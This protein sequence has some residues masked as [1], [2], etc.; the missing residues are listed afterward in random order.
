MDNISYNFFLQTGR[1]LNSLESSTIL[2]TGNVH[3]YFY[4]L[5][6]KKYVPIIEFLKSSMSLNTNIIVTYKITGGIQ[7][8]NKND[9][10]LFSNAW[11]YWR[12]GKENAEEF[13]GLCRTA[14]G[15]ITYSLELLKQMC[16]CSMAVD[17][18]NNPILEKKLLI[19]IEGAES[20]IPA[21]PVNQISDSDRVR[22]QICL[23]WFKDPDFVESKDAVILIAES[24]GLISP[25]ISR[26]PH[27]G[28][29]PIPAPNEEQRKHFID[30]YNENQVK[31]YKVKLRGKKNELAQLTAGLSILALRRL[32]K[33]ASHSRGELKSE[34]VMSEVKSF[35]ERELG[36]IVEFKIPSHNLSDVIGCTKIKEYV[37]KKVVPRFKSI[38]KDSLPGAAICG[39]IG[40][41][42]TF[43]WEAVAAESGMIVLVLGKLRDKWF[44][45]SDVRLERLKRILYA[46]VNVL[47]FIDEADAQ[48]S[49]LSA[50]EQHATEKRLQAGILSMMSDTKLRGKV[51]WLLLTARIDR[52]SHDM[53][54]PGRPGSLVIPMFDPEE[55]DRNE[56]L[57]WAIEP[58]L[59]KKLDQA[60]INKIS[61]LTEGYFAAMFSE[62]RSELLAES[63]GKKLRQ[64]EI[65]TVIKDIVQPAVSRTRK[66]Q[67]L[68]AKI[69]CNRRSL[70]PKDEKKEDWEAELLKLS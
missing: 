26:L 28:E 7:F 29:I 10:K 11:E 46:F 3:D 36:D 49:S 18:N 68:C 32:L 62:L 19:I 14:A 6:L 24:K 48:F 21:T 1:V 41:G 37:K 39:P 50:G 45:E 51:K 58:V 22:L 59:E 43:F 15:N 9:A 60:T 12:Y 35:I 56:F 53:L 44:G 5:K 47:I 61:K 64:E 55:N 13:Q 34:D 54:R 65:E 4:A 57:R 33:N 27:L 52:L 20:I 42:K 66:Y 17:E 63:K 70:L 30:W 25:V 69:Y 67:T 16:I 40:S 31:S 2:M 23:D 8:Q 38:G